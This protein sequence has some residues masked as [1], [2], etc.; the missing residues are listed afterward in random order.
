[1]GSVTIRAPFSGVTTSGV[2]WLSYGM[3]V[4]F[5]AN[6]K[7]LIAAIEDSCEGQGGKK[8][9]I[10]PYDSSGAYKGVIR[11]Q[12]LRSLTVTEGQW[13]FGGTTIG[14]CHPQIPDVTTCYYNQYSAHAHLEARGGSWSWPAAMIGDNAT[15]TANVTPIVTFE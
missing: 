1:V 6:G 2:N 14:Y 8:V 7:G 4:R 13:I 11:Y 3:Q 12:H 5:Y 15:L 10:A 9:D